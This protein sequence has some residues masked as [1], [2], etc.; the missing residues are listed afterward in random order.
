MKIPLPTFQ[1]E[2]SLWKTGLQYIAGIDEVGRGA[3]AG[4]VVAAAV[5]LPQD[6]SCDLPIHDSK[7]LSAKQR[8]AVAGSIQQKSLSFAIA[9]ISVLWINKVG[10]GK[11]TQMAF[12]KAIRLLKQQPEHVLIDAFLVQEFP[13]EKQTPI[14]HGDRL[15]ISIAAASIIAKVYRDALM[16]DLHTKYPVYG[17]AENKGYGTKAHQEALRQFGLSPMHRTSFTLDRFLA[18]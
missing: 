4:P 16:R 6:F 3:F 18:S 1:Y 8:E 11:A 17:F 9:E 12:R 10:I 7:L 5:I 2:Q 14:V 13:K 15:S